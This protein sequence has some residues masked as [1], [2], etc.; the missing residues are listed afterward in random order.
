MAGFVL[1]NG[2]M[3]SNTS[4]EGEIRKRIVEAD[5]VDCMVALPPQLF[6]NSGIPACLW[7]ISRDRK[8]QVFRNRQNEVLF[9]DARKMGVMVDRTH[10]ELTD[11]ELERIATV[12]HC[13]RSEEREYEDLRGFCKSASIGDIKNHNYVLAPGRYVG[14]EIIVDD[15]ETFEEKMT[16]LLDTLKT[17]FKEG[18]KLEELIRTNLKMS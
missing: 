3:S 10:R 1:A 13:W 8:N 16:L 2:S 18:Q 4:G 9:I 17:Q 7:F 5:L 6:Y 15:D 11:N 14:T 12:Y